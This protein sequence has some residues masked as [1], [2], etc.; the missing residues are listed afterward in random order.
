MDLRHAVCVSVFGESAS[1]S[2]FTVA[3]GVDQFIELLDLV[4]EL[5]GEGVWLKDAG[6]ADGFRGER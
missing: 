4:A 2:R 3:L 1:T 5:D 6:V